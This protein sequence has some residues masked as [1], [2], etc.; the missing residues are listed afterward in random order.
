M[1]VTI[2]KRPYGLAEQV[3]IHNIDP[4][5]QHFLESHNVKVS[6]ESVVEDRQVI[7]YGDYGAV[8]SNGDPDEII[9]ISDGRS[10]IETMKELRIF[11][12]QRLNEEN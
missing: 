1:I 9:V 4:A 8:D 3:R 2:F 7:V 12:E 10:C 11:V 6:M 5:D